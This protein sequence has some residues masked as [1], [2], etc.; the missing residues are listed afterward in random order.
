MKELGEATGNWNRHCIKHLKGIEK[1]GNQI[2]KI[3]QTNNNNNNN[4][5]EPNTSRL[6]L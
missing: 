1:V 6:L 3:Q 4:N 5:N 2:T